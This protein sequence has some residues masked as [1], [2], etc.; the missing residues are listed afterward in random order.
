MTKKTWFKSH[1]QDREFPERFLKP[2]TKI[3][4]IGTLVSAP[5]NVKEFLEFKFGKGMIENP[6]YPNP[7]KKRFMT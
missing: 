2:L 3:R 4:F 7:N 6:Q 5:N 1:K